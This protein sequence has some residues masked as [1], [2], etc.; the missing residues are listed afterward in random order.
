MLIIHCLVTG[1]KYALIKEYALN[2][3]VR[4]LTRVYGTSIVP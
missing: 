4:L 1:K 2:K 3:H